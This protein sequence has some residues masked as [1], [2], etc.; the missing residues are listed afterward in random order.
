MTVDVSDE[1]PLA[2]RDLADAD[3]PELVRAALGRF[4]RRLLVRVLILV[5]I[6]AVGVFLYPRYHRD[7][8]DLASEIRHAPG[9]DLYNTVKAGTVEATIMRVARLPRETLAPDRPVERFGIDLFVNGHSP[10]P[11]QQIVSLLRSDLDR[12]VLSFRIESNSNLADGL[13]MW[14]TFI[15]G[16]RT[17]DI[18]IA[19]VAVDGGAAR[20]TEP[21]LGTLHIDMQKLGVPDWTWR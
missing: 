18:P 5:L 16:T 12:G 2:L 9:V 4:R 10:A 13:E 14:I 7:A 15:A 21:S 8:G 11:D 17:I 1:R 6:A 19:R 3:S 20:V